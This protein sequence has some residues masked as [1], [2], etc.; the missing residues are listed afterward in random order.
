MV[1]EKSYSCTRNG[2]FWTVQAPTPSV[3]VPL[4]G[5]SNYRTG[6]NFGNYSGGTA[7]SCCPCRGGYGGG[8]ASESGYPSVV[9]IAVV[10][11]VVRVDNLILME[12]IISGRWRRF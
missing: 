2:S 8:G 11:M 1:A 12:I 6:G 10:A 9:D 3:T 5:V 4:G 7:S